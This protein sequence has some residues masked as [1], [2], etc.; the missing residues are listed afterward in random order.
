[1]TTGGHQQQSCRSIICSR[2]QAVA[3]HLTAAAPAAAVTLASE[4]AFQ[5]GRVLQ[6][7]SSSEG[8][9]TFRHPTEVDAPLFQHMH[10]TLRDE[11]VYAR[12]L[13][14]PSE[15]LGSAV[16]YLRTIVACCQGPADPFAA[17]GNADY[18]VVEHERRLV[19]EGFLSWPKP[20]HPCIM[21]D[22]SDAQDHQMPFLI[23]GI[24]LVEASTGLGIGK[25]L[26]LLLE[27]RAL[28]LG[29]RR[30]NL[31]VWAAN[32]RALHVYETLEYM[33]VQVKDMGVEGRLI[34]MMKTLDGS[35]SAIESPPPPPM[36]SD[37]QHW[38]TLGFCVFPSLFSPEE[39][40]EMRTHY[41]GSH[42]QGEGF[43]NP[44]YPLAEPH[45]R[46]AHWFEI[47]RHPKL[48]DAIETLIGPD[49]VLVFSSFFTKAADGWT[50][51]GSEKL[52]MVSF[53]QDNIYVSRPPLLHTYPHV[54]HTVQP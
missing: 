52:S 11:E 18:I 41:N 1:M 43:Q 33:T 16:D 19:G 9:V 50:T 14:F 23:L 13:T 46:Q 37:P 17:A 24:C 32:S 31:S 25:R 28:Q 5:P 45:T 27:R 51:P 21:A 6:R 2:L 53:H 15:Q 3:H 29:A 49:I 54:T 4:A 40:A 30:L 48:L 42:V 7:F 20:D 26:M 39:V 34:Q 36:N 10:H 44:N 47:C 12:R 8:D 22:G 35:A 38:D